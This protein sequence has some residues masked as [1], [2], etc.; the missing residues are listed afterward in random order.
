MNEHLAANDPNFIE[1]RCTAAT[2]EFFNA[3]AI[4]FEREMAPDPN[5]RI[6]VSKHG[7]IEQYTMFS[8]NFAY[9]MGAFSY[10]HSPMRY[11]K[12]GRYCS[13][14][15]GLR[16]F[17]E[18]HS[19]EWVTT[20]NITYCFRP[21]WNKPNFLRAHTD[22]MDSQWKPM[23]PSYWKPPHVSDPALEHDVWIA[24]MVTLARDITIGTGAV[25]GAGAIVTK[26][27][28]PYMIVAGNPA[29]PI[30]Q[31]FSDATCERFLASRWWELHPN[32]LFS[33]D[34][35]DPEAFLDRV[36]AAREMVGPCPVRGFTWD[37]VLREIG[38]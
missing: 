32:A 27:V 25:V 36:E 3:N 14:G 17:G 12:A 13:I 18:R 20:S 1:L 8:G 6:Q 34:A 19:M 21:D 37:D 24:E 28:P 15:A 23:N 33:L 4:F 26:S 31:R 30:R 5:R 11:L 38:L 10:S 7:T 2:C 29:R 9:P 22:L 35:R 16:V